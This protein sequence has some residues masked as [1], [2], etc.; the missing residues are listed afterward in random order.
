MA[1]T[2]IELKV[3]AVA[4]DWKANPIVIL[5]EAEGHRA[6]FI[7]VG[8]SEATAISMHLENQ[9]PPRPMTHDLIALILQEVQVAVERVKVSDMQ[10][11]TYYATLDLRD[12][13]D[14]TS[15]DCRPSDAIAV[16]LRMRAPIYIDEELLNRLDEERKDSGVELSPGAMIV[17]PGEPTVH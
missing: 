11:S 15:I 7:W 6:V 4:L 1:S 13:D 17:E 8:P 9:R 16:A 3:E 14:R 12:G 5:R 10:G 2:E